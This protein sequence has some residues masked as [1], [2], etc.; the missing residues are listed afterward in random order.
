[1]DIR[2]SFSWSSSPELKLLSDEDGEDGEHAF[3]FVIPDD[4]AASF[5]PW[6]ERPKLPAGVA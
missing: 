4:D 6:P 3:L 1:V 2:N 5:P